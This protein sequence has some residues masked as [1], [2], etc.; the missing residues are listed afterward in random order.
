V[1]IIDKFASDEKFSIADG[2]NLNLC[3]LRVSWYKFESTKR[4]V[5]AVMTCRCFV[6]FG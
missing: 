5:E 6:C 2:Q 3:D 4:V 1:L